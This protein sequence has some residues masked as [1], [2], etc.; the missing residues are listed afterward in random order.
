M[1][2][3]QHFTVVFN[4]LF[5]CCSVRYGELWLSS[6]GLLYMWFSSCASSL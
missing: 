2:K 6:P 5:V 4:S 3:H 1:N